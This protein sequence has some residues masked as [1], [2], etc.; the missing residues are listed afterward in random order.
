MKQEIIQHALAEGHADGADA[1][2]VAV[3]TAR[4]L[5]L[6]FAELEP[7]V[8]GPAVHAL[9]TRSLHLARSS[10]ERPGPAEP[11]P[12]SEMLTALQQDL[13]AR[14]PADARRAGETLLHTSADLLVSLIGEPLTNRLLL[15]AWGSP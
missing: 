5:R 12:P 11:E 7:L 6:L 1:N 8:G 15:S 14:V 9:Y 4:A 3:A 10:F 2:T 13:A